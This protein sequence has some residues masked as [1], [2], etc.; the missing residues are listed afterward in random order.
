MT[1]II[2]KW[3]DINFTVIN[4]RDSKDRFIISEVEEVMGNLEDDILQVSQMMGSKFVQEIK[5]D[6]EKWEI[7]LGYI[8]DVID[9][10]TSFQVKWMYLEN[11]F[12]ADDIQ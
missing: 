8:S 10:W 3:D 6:V 2:E 4:Y 9:D 1:E 12:N 11:I 5:E 7:K